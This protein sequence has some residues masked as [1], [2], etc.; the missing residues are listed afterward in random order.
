MLRAPA[1]VNGHFAAN[2]DPLGLSERELPTVMDPKLYGF[3]ESDMD[4]ECAPQLSCWPLQPHMHPH[5]A[6]PPC[7]IIEL[8]SCCTIL[9]QHRTAC[10]HID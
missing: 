4:R 2:L 8:P 10:W 5:T 1:Q 3:S 9:G 6:K 7:S